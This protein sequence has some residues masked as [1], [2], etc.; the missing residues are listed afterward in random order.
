ML[1]LPN[2]IIPGAP[3]SATTSLCEYLNQHENVF[4]PKLKE[5]RYFIADIIKNLPKEDSIKESLVNTSTLTIDAYKQLYVD[6]IQKKFRCDASVQYLYYHDVVIP[7]IK[8]TLGDPSIIIVLRD[9]ISR[10]FSNFS[11]M[12]TEVKTNTFEQALALEAE[13][14]NLGWNSFWFY[15]SQGLYYEQVKHFKAVFSR[16]KVVLMEDF[17]TQTENTMREVFDFLA[18]DNIVVD[19]QVIY[20][21]SGVPKNKLIEW[22][23]FENSFLKKTLKAIL[24]SV[25]SDV[26][27]RRISRSIKDKLLVK[28]KSEIN[29]ETH[30]QLVKIY[31]EDVLKLQDLINRDLTDWIQPK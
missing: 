28:S 30:N 26:D 20:N 8:K 7:N 4:V 22:F 15:V 1:S 2:L 12:G 24:N 18:L 29:S 19:T 6:G 10:A 27:R 25:Y 16:V 23:I 3:K 5:P 9:P 13:R 17:K 11:Y 21:K 14:K 31:K